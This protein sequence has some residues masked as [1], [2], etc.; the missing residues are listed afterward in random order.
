MTG[1]DFLGFNPTSELQ[2]ASQKRL[3]Q[4]LKI[5]TGVVGHDA[6]IVRTKSGIFEGSVKIHTGWDTFTVSAAQDSPEQVLSTL[7]RKMKERLIACL[8]MRNPILPASRYWF[9]RLDEQTRY[10]RRRAS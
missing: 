6:Y 1:F 3:K 5:A 4:L 9:D 7:C 10:H 8:R 2:E